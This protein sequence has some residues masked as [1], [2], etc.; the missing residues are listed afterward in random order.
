MVWG[1]GAVCIPVLAPVTKGLLCARSSACVVFIPRDNP[2]GRGLHLHN[3]NAAQKD[4]VT[5]S[6]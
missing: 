6:E 4:Q 2:M 1:P 3:R 5:A